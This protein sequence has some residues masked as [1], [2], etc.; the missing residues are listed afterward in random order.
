MGQCWDLCSHLPHLSASA[1]VGGTCRHTDFTL[2][3]ALSVVSPAPSPVD[4][5]SGCSLFRFPG[6][7][8]YMDTSSVQ[9]PEGSNGVA[10]GTQEA[11]H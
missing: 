7:C 5:A 1:N 4:A 8:L 10:M 11:C 2:S 6:S 3:Q 9:L